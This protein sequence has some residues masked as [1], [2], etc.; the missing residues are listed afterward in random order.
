[1]PSKNS[2]FNKNRARGFWFSCC[3]FGSEVCLKDR[4]RSDWSHGFSWKDEAQTLSFFQDRDGAVDQDFSTEM[5]AHLLLPLED[6]GFLESN[7]AWTLSAGSS[8][9]GRDLS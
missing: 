4:K 1:M 7:L 5:L 6:R 3:L 9:W 2:N 8:E